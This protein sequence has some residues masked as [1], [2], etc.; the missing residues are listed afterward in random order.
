[1]R[2]EIGPEYVRVKLGI[3]VLFYST[4]AHCIGWWLNKVY[5]CP[6]NCRIHLLP[7]YH[8]WNLPQWDER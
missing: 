8:V 6:S 4:H 2:L 7:K 3:L 5:H 1:V